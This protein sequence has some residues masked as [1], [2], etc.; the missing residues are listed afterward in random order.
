LGNVVVLSG[1]FDPIHEGHIA[2]FEE[3]SIKYDKVIVGIN[4][5]SWLKRK[6]GNNFQSL[7]TRFAILTS[8]KYI[9]EVV[10]FD[11]S[12]DTAIK[13]IRKIKDRNIHS[14]LTFGNGGDRAN[15]NFPEKD[16]CLNNRVLIDGYLGGTN[17]VNSSS[18]TLNNYYS[19]EAIRDWGTWRVLKSYSKHTKIKELTVSPG[20]RLSWQKHSKRS[21]LWFIRKGTATVHSSFVGSRLTTINYIQDN[22]VLLPVNCWHCLENNT[23]KEISVIEI[24]YGEDC[25]ETDIYRMD[26]PKH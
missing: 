5:D 8:I 4:S 14:T 25:I 26:F 24:Q 16:Y 10:I 23:D 22:Y 21:E 13:L 2:M 17:K 3:A 9:D 19:E 15:G 7:A 6:K 1:G 12:D 18:T 11:D 20:K